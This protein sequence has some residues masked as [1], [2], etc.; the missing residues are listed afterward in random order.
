MFKKILS[1]VE[2]FILIN[3]CTNSGKTT[4]RYDYFFI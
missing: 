4:Q 1:E 3:D 2:V